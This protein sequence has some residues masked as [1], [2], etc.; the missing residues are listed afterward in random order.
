[1]LELDHFFII[2]EPQANVAELLVEI[3]FEE[4]YSRIHLGQGTSNRCFKFSN[5]MMELLWL[6]D[7]EEA[8]NGPAKGLRLT[9]RSHEKNASPFGLIFNRN[10]QSKDLPSTEVPFEG[11]RYQ[12]D[13]SPPPNAFHVAANSTNLLEPL[14]IY[15]PFMEP[16]VRVVEKGLFKSISQVHLQVPVESLSE[17]L[18]IASQS[19]GVTVECGK[20][21]LMEVTFDQH[22]MGLSKDL[23]PCLPLVIHW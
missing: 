7:E 12:P 11:W 16:V 18:L 10:I 1:M 2:V 23:R 19:Q 8:N 22:T 17:E 21:H 6:R 14:C 15:I 9:E 13:Y 4:S 3:G 5:S 20:E